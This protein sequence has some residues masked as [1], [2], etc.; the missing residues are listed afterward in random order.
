[1]SCFWVRI[2][3]S[4]NSSDDGVICE[5]VGSFFSSPFQ[6]S[7]IH[8]TSATP[9]RKSTVFFSNRLPCVCMC[10][11]LKHLLPGTPLSTYHRCNGLFPLFDRVCFLSPSV[12]LFIYHLYL[13]LLILCVVSVVP[14]LFFLL[15]FF[16]FWCTLGVWAAGEALDPLISILLDTLTEYVFFLCEAIRRRQHSNSPS[17]F[18][19]VVVFVFFFFISEF[20]SQRVFFSS[21]LW[22]LTA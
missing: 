11:Q 7:C 16:P 2:E 20:V 10:V 17:S 9:T 13:F 1:M 22:H 15:T 3:P 14:F 4:L 21:L 19:S 5:N 12:Y 6:R 8:L 18:A